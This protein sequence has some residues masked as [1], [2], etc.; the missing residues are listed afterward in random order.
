MGDEFGPRILHFDHS[1]VLL[2]PPYPVPGGLLSPNN[3]LLP[4]GTAPTQPNSRG[5]EAMAI[6]YRRSPS[7]RLP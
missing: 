1:G 5:I 7:L 6:K 2:D 3:P 4:A